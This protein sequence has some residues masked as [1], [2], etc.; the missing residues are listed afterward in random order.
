MSAPLNV[1]TLV[2]A[3]LSTCTETDPSNIALAVLEQIEPKDYAEALRQCLRDVVRIEAGRLRVTAIPEPPKTGSPSQKVA[4]IKEHWRKVL[5][6]LEHTAKGEWR[7]LGD[8]TRDDL[9]AAAEYRVR[10]ADQ[11]IAKAEQYR[12][13]AALV[14]KHRVTCLRH[15]PVAALAPVLERQVAA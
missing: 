4:A 3:T 9:L 12:E 15:V 2:R 1:H 14:E 11:S 7:H 10:Q 8:F 5:E 13:L 6:S